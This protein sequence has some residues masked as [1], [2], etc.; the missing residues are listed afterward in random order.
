MNDKTALLTPGKLTI[1]ERTLL[2]QLACENVK[3]ALAQLQELLV[4]SDSSS[5]E[6]IC[7][8]HDKI[9]AGGID[10]SEEK[11]HAVITVTDDQQEE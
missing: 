4:Y 3:E 9:K 7:S 8:L 2:S 11:T 1:E 5:A 6:L 10:F